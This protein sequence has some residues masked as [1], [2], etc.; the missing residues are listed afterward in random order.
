M[1]F[2]P[3]VHFE[4]FRSRFT[5][6]ESE[7]SLRDYITRVKLQSVS[8]EIQ[9]GLDSHPTFEVLASEVKLEMTRNSAKTDHSFS[10]NSLQVNLICP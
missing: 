5:D 2:D 8:I 6:K 4:Q 9:P 10:A 3:S 1:C 7:Y